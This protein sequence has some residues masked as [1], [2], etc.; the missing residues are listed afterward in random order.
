MNRR[1]FLTL[2][3]AGLLVST[4]SIAVA[5][6]KPRRKAKDLAW[7][8]TP[9]GCSYSDPLNLGRKVGLRWSQ[10]GGRLWGAVALLYR[11]GD[12]IPRNVMDIA[13]HRLM[14]KLQAWERY[15]TPLVGVFSC[16]D[17]QSNNLA[18]IIGRDGREE[19]RVWIPG[20]ATLA[21]TR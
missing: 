19:R 7:F 8:V 14:E 9:A 13:R 12:P 20:T 2:P 4:T 5:G 21:S 15:E 3:V 16:E 18:I 11:V 6:S 17:Y 1:G 10:E